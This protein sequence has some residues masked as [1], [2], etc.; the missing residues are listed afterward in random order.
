MKPGLQM[1]VVSAHFAPT[2]NAAAMRL[3]PFVEVWAERGWDVKV[4]TGNIGAQAPRP[5]EGY[6]ITRLRCRVPGNDRS[7]AV[8]LLLEAVSACELFWRMLLA[9]CDAAF[10]TSPPVTW[11]FVA[12]LAAVL[13]RK[14]YVLDVRDLYPDVLYDAGVVS[15]AGPIG[16]LLRRLE[17]Y[18]YRR[19]KGVVTVTTGLVEILR[20][21][22]WTPVLLIPNGFDGKV[23]HPAP[24]ADGAVGPVRLLFHGTLGRFQDV[25]LLVEYAAF[26]KAAGDRRIR[27]VVAGGGPKRT[28]LEAAIRDHGLAD[29][30]DYRGAVDLAA[31]VALLHESD[32]G[33]SFRFES[34]IDLTAFPVKVYEYMACGLPVVVFPRGEPGELVERHGAGVALSRRDVQVLHA[35]IERLLDAAERARLGRNALEASRSFER[36]TLAATLMENMSDLMER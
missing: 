11:A 22:T 36:R 18:G 12:V 27:I 28:A 16:R 35:A 15:E 10:I 23:F 33:L 19:A 5:P 3:A 25:E 1:L 26:L 9:R 24:A 2:A 34:S 30:L 14:P 20:K 21:R 29:V 6:G 17:R 13:R 32:V 8:R 4:L 7:V 31:V